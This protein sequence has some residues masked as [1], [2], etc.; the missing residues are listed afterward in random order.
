MKINKNQIFSVVFIL[1]M[2]ANFIV[3]HFYQARYTELQ[4]V[5]DGMI[6][7][8]LIVWLLYFTRIYVMA[9]S[10]NKKEEANS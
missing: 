4:Y 5:F 10:N 1:I 9:W 3:K 2:L 7:G 6:V 8:L